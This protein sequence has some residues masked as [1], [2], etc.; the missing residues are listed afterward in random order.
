MG[1][2]FG[3]IGTS[4][5]YTLSVIF[6]TMQ[7]TKENV[8]SVLSLILW[9]LILIVF[10][11]Y[12]FF[13]MSFS[14][15]GEGGAI[16]LN[17]VL[18][19]LLKSSRATVFFSYLTYIGISLL[20]G[21]SI[22]TPAISIL[23]AVEGLEF[24]PQLAHTPQ[25]IIV[26]ITVIITILLFLFQRK[27]VE[28]V[29]QVFGPIM[30]IWF[31]ALAF[32]GVFSLFHTPDVIQAFNP[33][34]ALKF[35]ATNSLV[36]FF[37]LSEVIL[38]VTGAEALYADMGHLGRKPIIHAWYF[39]FIALVCNYLGQG[40]FLINHPNAK[41]IIFEMVSSE[42]PI[43]YIPFLFVSILAT[44]IASQAMISGL[45]S[46]I[47]Q[48]INVKILPLLKINFTSPD[49]KSQIY[50]DSVNWMLMVCVIFTILLFKKSSALAGAYGFA[51]SGAILITGLMLST[52]FL[53]KRKFFHFIAMLGLLVFDLSLFLACFSKLEHGALWAV[54]FAIF[55]L[56]VIILY[57][58]GSRVL[59]KRMYPMMYEHFLEKYLFLI[60]KV[61]KIS[62]TALFFTM[63]VHKIP[64]YIVNTMFVNNIVYTDNVFVS[65]NKTNEPHDVS[66]EIAEIAE[67]LRHL[68]IN[69]GYMEI[70]NLQSI[71][72]KV[73]I[74]EKAIFY[75]IE[76]I[77]S[78]NPLWILF[79]KIKKLAPSFMQFYKLPAHKVHGVTT[80]V[81][82]K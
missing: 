28:K 49:L 58:N 73:R 39:V 66:W 51:V 3:D 82:M 65:I 61:N 47:Y 35:L 63:G 9:T 62:G 23:S 24:I 53:L 33:L 75:G 13:A 71:F 31:L 4:P 77:E 81:E 64:P 32:S 25:A 67:G 59:Y 57:I 34:C 70:L 38:C 79:A 11:Q 43:L 7:A 44:I 16:V 29:T 1:L 27:G 14:H 26:L 41:V 76:D 56:A 22:I 6:L 20:I 46:V 80:L 30:L 15:R 18:K 52:I 69:A 48:S 36:G 2:V 12:V 21:D 72:K 54:A 60:S 74:N 5:I 42:S 45:F 8:I 37:V 17:E 19:K 10:V 68:K 55:P 50:I 40:A 78:R